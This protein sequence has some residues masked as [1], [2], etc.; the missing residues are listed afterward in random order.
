MLRLGLRLIKV[1]PVAAQQWAQTAI[2]GGVMQS[3]DDTAYV[4]HTNGPEGINRNGKW[5]SIYCG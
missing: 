4:Q 3:N 1:D 2:T 5:R